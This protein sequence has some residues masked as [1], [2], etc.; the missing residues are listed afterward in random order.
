MFDPK[1]T[2]KLVK[3]LPKIMAWACFS[4]R[5]RGGL[6]FLKPGETM[7]GVRYRQVLE[8]KLE[9]FMAQHN[10]THFIQDGATCHRS[11]VMTKWFAERSTFSSSNGQATALISTQ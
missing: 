9:L 1:Y 11:K 10:S 4:W 7:N 3:H 2:R 5:G 6:G 8:D